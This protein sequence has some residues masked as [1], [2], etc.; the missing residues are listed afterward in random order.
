M[1]APAAAITAAKSIGGE[2]G[3]IIRTVLNAMEK[4]I[5]SNVS[6]ETVT[7]VAD[8]GD[9]VVRTRV[10][11]WTIPL[12]L[13]V[14]VI[15]SVAAWEVGNFIAQGLSGKAGGTVQL[16]TDILVPGAW[17]VSAATAIPG[18]VASGQAD[19]QAIASWLAGAKGK[20]V[21]EAGAPPPG[22]NVYVKPPTAMASMSNLVQS[23]VDP[24]AATGN[25]LAGK[26]IT[27]IGSMGA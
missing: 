27:S 7:H 1:A 17:I 25:T 10:K 21:A 16:V 8:N 15:G 2:T 13:P 22:A 6:T 4:P 14:L 20:T 3:G 9:V 23:I 19:V 11:G 26:L 12:G 18:L 24:I 5:Y